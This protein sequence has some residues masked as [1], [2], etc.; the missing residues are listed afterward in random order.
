MWSEFKNERVFGIGTPAGMRRFTFRC[1]AADDSNDKLKPLHNFIMLAG[2][3]G[4]YILM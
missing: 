2:F 1:G 4:F 3:M